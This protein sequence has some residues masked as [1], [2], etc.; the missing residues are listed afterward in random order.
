[1]VGAM[2]LPG[3]TVLQ[4]RSV[5]GTEFRA[6]T[7]VEAVKTALLRVFQEGREDATDFGVVRDWKTGQ[8]KAILQTPPTN[9]SVVATPDPAAGA[10]ARSATV[11]PVA[12]GANGPPSAPCGT[13]S[14]P[15]QAGAA[16]RP[17]GGE[18]TPAEEARRAG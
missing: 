6:E 10:A 5:I 12:P 11:Q 7:L 2:V 13:A 14:T 8:M 18:T 4:L 16:D 15:A 9:G 17:F 1:M 3:D